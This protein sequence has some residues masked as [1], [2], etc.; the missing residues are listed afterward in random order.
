MA[1]NGNK[2]ENNSKIIKSSGDEMNLPHDDTSD[3]RYAF[4]KSGIEYVKVYFSE[5]RYFMSE[6]V[7]VFI[8]TDSRRIPLRVKLDDVYNQLQGNN[9]F[10]IH[11][12]YLVNIDRIS[13]IGVNQVVIEG[14]ELPMSKK[15]KKNLL[16][17]I[18][19][20]K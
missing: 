3:K 4:F 15:Y 13:R 1:L 18:D 11:Q 5:I 14:T 17:Q 19:I 2:N 7:Y 9:F 12:R 6:H 20:M 16:D 8:V 10:R